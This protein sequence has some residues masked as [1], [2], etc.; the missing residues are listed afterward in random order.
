MYRQEYT[1][2]SNYYVAIES[3]TISCS[4]TVDSY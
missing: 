4:E 2:V 3:L 1:K